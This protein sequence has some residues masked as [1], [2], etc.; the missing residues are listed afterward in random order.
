MWGENIINY[1]RTRMSG[2][3]NLKCLKAKAEP[4]SFFPGFVIK[5]F[6]AQTCNP[7]TQSANSTKDTKCSV[8]VVIDALPEEGETT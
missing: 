3:T 6:P 4:H 5:T 7:T 8:G 1:Q 2:C